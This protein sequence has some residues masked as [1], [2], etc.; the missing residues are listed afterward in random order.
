MLLLLVVLVVVLVEVGWC[1]GGNDHWCRGTGARRLSE[2]CSRR[3]LM[4]GV[5]L[6]GCVLITAVRR[7]EHVFPIGEPQQA[8]DR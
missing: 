4:T 6:L 7:R 8:I 1:G 5:I 2:V 3:V